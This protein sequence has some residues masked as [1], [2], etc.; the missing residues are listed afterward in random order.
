[1]ISSFSIILYSMFF[2]TSFGVLLGWYKYKSLINPLSFNF[3]FTFFITN[4]LS[5]ISTLH[6]RIDEHGLSL[7]HN[8]STEHLSTAAWISIL[9]VLS[10]S[11]PFLIFSNK[12]SILIGNTFFPKFLL[13][14]H[15]QKLNWFK[16]L[17]IFMFFLF[18]FLL[19]AFSSDSITDWITDPRN[20][21]LYQRKGN[22]HFYLATVYF[23]LLSYILGLFLLKK[24]SSIFFWTVIFVLISFWTGKKAV[25]ITFPFIS[26][27][28]YHF[29]IKKI[30]S[31]YIFIFGL[32]FL[33]FLSL[34]VGYQGNNL[35]FNFILNYFNYIDVT[36]EMLARFDEFGYYLGRVFISSWWVMV[37]RSL[38]PDKP[39]EYG[40]SLIH[41]VLF[42]GLAETGHTSGY[43][44]WSGTYL[45]FGL[46]GVMIVS[47]L[48][49]L[50]I[51]II[52]E[53]FLLKNR[54]IILF[55]LLIHICFWPIWFFIPLIFVFI[56]LYFC[57]ITI[58]IKIN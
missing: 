33:I 4:F 37:P 52:F 54:S 58:K 8:F 2:F 1:M 57:N 55:M 26:I 9:N 39:F 46:L 19:L 10:F 44:M 56:W 51:K 53:Y 24:K 38:Y 28:F 22:G 14:S 45:D 27:I 43:L 16:V 6:S 42:P 36:A 20:S 50:F 48:N 29:Y 5:I 7:N 25:I 32:M 18:S 23:L 41:A 21:Y 30:N 11:I 40:D 31:I 34:I 35:D 13:T 15:G 47:F 17:L 12:L 3:I 49:G